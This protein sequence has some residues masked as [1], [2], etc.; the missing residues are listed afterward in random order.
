MRKIVDTL[1]PTT[2]VGSYP[3]P[4]WFHYQLEGRD[5][6]DAMKWTE[7]AQAYEDAT[8]AVIAEQQDMGLDI[9]TDG[10]MHYD[11]YGGSIGSFVWY[12]YER[13]PGFVGKKLPNPLSAHGA[14]TEVGDAE[15]FHDWGGT[16]TTGK[17]QRAP[18]RLL[19]MYRIASR[20][21]SRPL[22]VSVGAGP[23]NLGFHVDYQYPGS[24]YGRLEDLTEDLVPIFNAELKELA[25]AGAEFIQLEDL[26]AWYPAMTHSDETM[27]WVVDVINRTVEGVDAKIAWHFCLGNATGL[28]FRSV[29]DALEQVL[30]PLYETHV[31]QY[32]LD[33]AMRDMVDV[34]ALT[35]LPRDKEV[36]IGVIDVRTN[37]PETRDEVADRM[38]KVLEVVPAEQVYFTTDCGLKPL[39]RICAREKLRS[40]ARAAEVVRSEVGAPAAR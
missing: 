18:S 25:A 13:L 32:V 23:I 8:T 1:L 36:A 39:P 27:R 9:V 22:K 33:F 40:L 21:A 30:P 31:E 15:F 26:G 4:A 14:F 34:R 38:R 35:N 10:Q 17:V 19:E 16:A 3:R 6:L 2:M 20:H 7:F 11:D 24:A 29:E 37:T 28:Y 12:W 5:L